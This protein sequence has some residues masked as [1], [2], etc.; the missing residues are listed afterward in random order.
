MVSRATSGKESVFYVSDTA[1]LSLATV[2]ASVERPMVESDW[3]QY[4]LSADTATVKEHLMQYS[5]HYKGSMY[6]IISRVSINKSKF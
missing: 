4:N 6:N 5:L 3:L 2:P 1:A